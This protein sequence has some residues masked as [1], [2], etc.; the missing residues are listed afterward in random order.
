MLGHELELLLRDRVFEQR[1]KMTQMIHAMFAG[2]F[3]GLFDRQQRVSSGQGQQADQHAH[4]AM[5]R[6]LSTASA[7]RAACGPTWRTRR[8]SSVA[9]LSTSADLLRMRYRRGRSEAAWLLACMQPDLDELHV[10]DAH[11]MTV[12]RTQTV[13]PMYSGGTE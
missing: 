12:Q 4:T 11:Q 6:S 2:Q 10:E 8:S 3:T 13:W 9:P 7:Q 1:S 5:M